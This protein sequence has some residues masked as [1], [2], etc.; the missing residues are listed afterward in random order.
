MNKKKQ[1]IHSILNWHYNNNNTHFFLFKNDVR[2]SS[3]DDNKMLD[4]TN[5]LKLENQEIINSTNQYKNELKDPQ[6]FSDLKTNVAPD[7]IPE[8]LCIGAICRNDKIIIPN[9]H[10]EIYAED[11]LLV[12]TK[13]ENISKVEKLFQ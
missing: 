10:T 13:E 3:S 1:L 9:N 11:E 8:E 2:L 4:S 5:N 6:R 7:Q 12:I